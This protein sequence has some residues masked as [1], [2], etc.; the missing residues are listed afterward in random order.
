MALIFHPALFR[1]VYSKGQD[2]GASV[3][4]KVPGGSYAAQKGMPRHADIE[5]FTPPSMKGKKI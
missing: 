1:T 3:P 5:P 2:R 4:M